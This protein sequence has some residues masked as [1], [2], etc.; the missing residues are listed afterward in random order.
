M[1]NVHDQLLYCNSLTI[2]CRYT[3][4][5]RLFIYVSTMLARETKHGTRRSPTSQANS[6]FI[7]AQNMQIHRQKS[8]IHGS[9][10]NLPPDKNWENMYTLLLF[11]FKFLMVI[12]QCNK[13][14]Q[15]KQTIHISPL[16]SLYS[17][18]TAARPCMIL[19]NCWQWYWKDRF[20]Q[21]K[22]LIQQ[23]G[24]KYLTLPP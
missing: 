24:V 22:I 4:L 13:Y 15:S 8:P 5:G 16:C 19:P 7:R 21:H 11:P 20:F 9:V 10:N 14:S 23:T 17:Q 2:F 6:A 12:L 18:V 1:K 3:F